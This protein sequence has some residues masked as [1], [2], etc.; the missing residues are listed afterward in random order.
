[1]FLSQSQTVP[2]RLKRS[3][4]RQS[5]LPEKKAKCEFLDGDFKFPISLKVRE[6][7]KDEMPLD[8]TLR[9]QLIRESVTCLQA[10]VGEDLTSEH[11]TEAAQKLCK[12]VPVL[13]DKRPP[14]WPKDIEF[15][16]W[17]SF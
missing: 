14:L 16:C 15:Q 10:Y 3:K 1:M 13:Q 11:F 5:H 8:D 12:E 9:R 6:C 17:V 7:V 4:P 2:W